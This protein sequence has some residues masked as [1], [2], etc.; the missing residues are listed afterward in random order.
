MDM[1]KIE[2]A[3]DNLRATIDAKLKA[4]VSEE[5]LPTDKR[6]LLDSF[7]PFFNKLHS[8]FKESTD[9]PLKQFYFAAIYGLVKIHAEQ[10]TEKLLCNQS[11]SLYLQSYFKTDAS[12]TY[13]TALD[14]FLSAH[15]NYFQ[16]FR[17]S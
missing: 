11:T 10:I 5:M 7:A 17:R 16:E 4:S 15:E 3:L 9:N 8:M 6:N 13:H 12:Q 1:K 2:E 14:T